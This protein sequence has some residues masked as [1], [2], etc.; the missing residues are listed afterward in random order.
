MHYPD[1]PNL[2]PNT[3]DI[4]IKKTGPFNF[5][6]TNILSENLPDQSAFLFHIHDKYKRI[7]GRLNPPEQFYSPP[8]KCSCLTNLRLRLL[9]F[10]ERSGI[11]FPPQKKKKLITL[12]LSFFQNF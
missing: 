11:P 8:K 2:K 5:Q 6:L 10:V 1:N 7:F 9:K 3:I 12:R 4:A